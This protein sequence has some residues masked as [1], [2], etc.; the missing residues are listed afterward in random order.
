MY[1]RDRDGPGTSPRGGTS[2]AGSSCA[3][4]PGEQ[5]HR[6][7]KPGRLVSA[8]ADR[9]GWQ[10]SA[11]TAPCRCDEAP[12]RSAN[13]TKRRR[14]RSAV[15]RFVSR[16]CAGRSDSGRCWA[17]DAHRAASR[18]R[19][20]LRDRPQPV[21]VQPGIDHGRGS[22]TVAQHI[23]H[24]VERSARV[25]PAGRKAMTQNV[26]S[27]IGR[28]WLLAGRRQASLR[29]A[30]TIWPSLNGRCGAR[31]VTNTCSRS[32]ALVPHEDIG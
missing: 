17:S 19:P 12:S 11:G 9:P 1:G 32:L 7:R 26:R 29:M 22:R 18:H 14:M 23:A 27:D 20:G 31:C 30:L 8:P 21:D 2:C 24:L 28:G 15:R 13:R 25:L 6:P 4:P 16:G 3:Q 5:A 10:A